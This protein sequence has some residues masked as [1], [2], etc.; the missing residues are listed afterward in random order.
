VDPSVVIR[1][2]NRFEAV[3]AEAM[4]GVDHIAAVAALAREIRETPGLPSA[5]A[6]ALRIMMEA[7]GASDPAGRFT[8]K[9]AILRE[10]RDLLL[11]D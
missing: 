11:I 6:N 10:A 3:A 5:V 2:A 4:D 1:F 9:V 8:A 7:I